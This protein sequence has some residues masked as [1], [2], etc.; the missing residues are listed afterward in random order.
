MLTYQFLI[1]PFIGA[2]SPNFLWVL[3]VVVTESVCSSNS[4][5]VNCQVNYNNTNPYPYTPYDPYYDP[6]A[7]YYSPGNS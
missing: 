2:G 5:N 3:G 6:N 7:P 4:S 1:V